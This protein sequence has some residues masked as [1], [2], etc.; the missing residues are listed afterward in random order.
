LQEPIASVATPA[1]RLLYENREGIIVERNL[2]KSTTIMVVDDETDIL[3]VMRSLLKRKGYN[4]ETFSDSL[5]ALNSFKADS[6]KY[7]LVISDIR[8]PKLNGFVLSKEIRKVSPE[9]K[10]V[11]M[12][13]F[14]I[15]KSEFDRVMPS[16]KINGFVAKP[17]H[18]SKLYEVIS[19]VIFGHESQ[20]WDERG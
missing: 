4:V 20:N 18:A 14:E 6:S 1:T 2:P 9:I 17:F 3:A 11:F 19:Q 12:T 15:D 16:L 5:L 13:A 10:I 8:M 7:D